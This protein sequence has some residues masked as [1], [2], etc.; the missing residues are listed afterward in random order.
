MNQSVRWLCF[1]RYPK[2]IRLK[3]LQ[4]IILRSLKYIISMFKSIFEMRDRLTVQ[5]IDMTTALQYH[6]HCICHHFQ[7]FSW[8]LR[9]LPCLL[10][11]RVSR[12]CCI[13]DGR[14]VGQKFLSRPTNFL[15][16]YLI[17]PIYLLISVKKIVLLDIS[18][19]RTFI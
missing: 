14:Y 8:L 19:A 15:L 12:N 18:F 9:N 11:L 2:T 13:F 5:N 4:S 10:R 16:T 7:I 6:E 17:K 3:S 1:V